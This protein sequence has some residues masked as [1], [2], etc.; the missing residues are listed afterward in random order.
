MRRNLYLHLTL[1]CSTDTHVV[2]HL[3]S[4]MP[5]YHAQEATEA[6]KKVLGKHYLFDDAHFLSAALV[7]QRRCRFVEDEGDLVW[8]KH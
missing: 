4:T 7:A 3:F 8:F 6:V 2:H 1:I 5:F